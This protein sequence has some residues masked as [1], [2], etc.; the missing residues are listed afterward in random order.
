MGRKRGMP[1]TEHWFKRQ[2]GEKGDKGKGKGGKGKDKGKGKGK[3]AVGTNCATKAPD[4]RMICYRFNNK[5][6]KC[7]GKCKFAHIC[8]VCFGNHPM[9]SDKCTGRATKA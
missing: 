6:E 7:E 8:G 9:Y 5:H 2:R 4:G 3:G 1:D